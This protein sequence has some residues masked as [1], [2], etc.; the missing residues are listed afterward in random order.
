MKT[1]AR[2]FINRDALFFVT[3]CCRILLVVSFDFCF[4]VSFDFVLMNFVLKYL[5]FEFCLE[6]SII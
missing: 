3:V 2:L 1:K 5:S 4:E 6:V